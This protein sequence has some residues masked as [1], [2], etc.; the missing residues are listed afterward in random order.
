MSFTKKFTNYTLQRRI[1]KTCAFWGHL[2]RSSAPQHQK[3]R[4]ICTVAW[5]CC[6]HGIAGVAFGSY[7]TNKL[8]SAVMQATHKK[9]A[10]PLLQAL[11]MAPKCDPVFL[12]LWETMGN[13]HCF[14][15]SRSS[16]CH[17]PA[18]DCTGVVTPASC[19][20]RSCRGLPK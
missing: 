3:L 20:P 14:Q 9:G 11:L 13:H 8:R 15:V 19:S 7:H 4:A 1:A 18:A 17:V 2:K 10:S 6:L 16:R 12:I 5:P